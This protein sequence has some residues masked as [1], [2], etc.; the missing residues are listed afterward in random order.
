MKEPLSLTE[1]G[2]CEGRDDG[3]VIDNDDLL[4][5][6]TM[7]GRGTTVLVDAVLLAAGVFVVEAFALG[8]IVRQERARVKRENGLRKISNAS[9]LNKLDASA[10]GQIEELTSRRPHC[11]RWTRRKTTR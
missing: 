2:G 1:D 4:A 5:R 3:K 7:T 10:R 8:G 11:T 9:A 6:G